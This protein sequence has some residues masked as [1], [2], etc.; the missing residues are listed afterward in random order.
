MHLLAGSKTHPH[1]T[2]ILYNPPPLQM[3]NTWCL[4]SAVTV[5][6]YRNK[7]F[8]CNKKS[9]NESMP[10][11]TFKIHLFVV[12]DQHLFNYTCDWQFVNTFPV[13]I[14]CISPVNTET[15][16]LFAVFW[17]QILLYSSLNCNTY[18]IFH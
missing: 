14:F 10:H 9:D 17:A 7:I 4:R 3:R 18:K 15:L 13:S 8:L 12:H 16:S 11:C 6:R 2:Y 5:I 1:C